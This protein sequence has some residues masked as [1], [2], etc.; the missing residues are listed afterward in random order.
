MAVTVVL[1]TQWGDEGKGKIVDYYAKDADYVVRF[2]GGSNAGHTIKVGDEVYKLHIT[3]SG[4]IQG[5]TGVIGNGVVVDLEVLLNEIKMLKEKGKKPKLLISDRAHV[6]MPYHKLL[7]G[8]EETYLRDQKIG[9]TKKGI[10]PCYSDKVARRGI[11][12]VDLLNKTVLRKKLEVILPIKQRLLSIYNVE[13]DLDID[14][15]TDTYAAYG[16]EIKPFVTNVSVKLNHAIEQ[17]KHILLE[18]A[19]GTML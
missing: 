18:G 15:L 9:T 7:D 14:E 4:V 8:A 16:K 17:G 2:Q 13:A 3:P 12:I 1:G 5:K 19:Q 6:I 11:R 10:G